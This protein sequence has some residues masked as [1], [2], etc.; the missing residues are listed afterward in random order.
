MRKL[1]KLIALLVL[2]NCFCVEN[3]LSQQPSI[4]FGLI[5]DVQYGDC[6]THGSRYYRNSIKKLESCVTDLNNRKVQFTIALGDFVDRNPADLAPVVSCLKKLNAKVYN[7]TGNHDYKGFTDNKKLFKKLNMPDEYYSF[8]KGDWRFILLNTNEIASYSNSK[9]TWK[10]KELSVL[11][12]RINT[13]GR[14]NAQDWNGGISSK[15]MQWLKSSLENAQK[16]GEK[17]LIFSHNPLYPPTEFTALNDQE[18]LDTI[19]AFS[20]VKGVFSGHHH[21][22]AFAYYKEIPCITTEGMI[23]TETEN[24]YGIVEIHTDRIVLTGYG[25]T[26]SY[27]L[28]IR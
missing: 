20:C 10:E 28:F 15:Q 2:L 27:E 12:E 23:E 18:I 8:K 4:R 24:A 25:R 11:L 5:A 26:K 6:D 22:G 16:K 21:T 9:D 19:A 7:T 1:K 3:V 17:V 13:T 14:N